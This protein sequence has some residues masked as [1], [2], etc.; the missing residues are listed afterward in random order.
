V[1]GRSTRGHTALRSCKDGSCARQE[2]G[3]VFALS[4]KNKWRDVQGLCPWRE[5]GGRA[6]RH[7]RASFPD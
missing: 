2:S 1:K 6:R 4:N 5:H 7:L 3:L